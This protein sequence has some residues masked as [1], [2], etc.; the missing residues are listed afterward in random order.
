MKTFEAGQISGQKPAPEEKVRVVAS[1]S[2]R[3]FIRSDAGKFYY[4]DQT[5]A[6]CEEVPED[7]VASAMVKHGYELV[8]AGVVFEFGNR[9]M[10]LRPQ[11]EKTSLD[12]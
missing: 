3:Y 9:E 4:L 2:D 1:L 5:L 12:Q 10:A 6:R 11:E 8:A 7:A